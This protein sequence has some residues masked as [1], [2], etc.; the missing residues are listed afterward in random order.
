MLLAE[1]E[2]WYCF[3]SESSSSRDSGTSPCLVFHSAVTP[4]SYSFMLRRTAPAAWTTRSKPTW[5]HSLSWLRAGEDRWSDDVNP[6]IKRLFSDVLFAFEV[7]MKL[8]N[9]TT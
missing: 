3:R 7:E 9:Y 5:I 4:E 6:D 1:R 2:G 8:R